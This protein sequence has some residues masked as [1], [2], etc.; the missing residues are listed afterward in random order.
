MKDAYK[1]IPNK[2][3]T[4]VEGYLIPYQTAVDLI[5]NLGVNVVEAPRILIVN[6]ATEIKK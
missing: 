4:T 5:Q 3:K 2:Y 6:S 1:M